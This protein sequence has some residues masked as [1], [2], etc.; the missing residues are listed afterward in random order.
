MDYLSVAIEAAKEAGKFLKMNLGKVKN[1]ERKRE[2][3]NL[4]TEIDK[5]EVDYIFITVIKGYTDK[6]FVCC[7]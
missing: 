6:F 4:V 1:I 3:I 7:F 5:G 2:E